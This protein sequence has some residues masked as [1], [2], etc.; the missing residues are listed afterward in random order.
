M[1]NTFVELL[2]SFGLSSLPAL[3]LLCVSAVSKLI[4]I[5][6]SPEANTIFSKPILYMIGLATY[7]IYFHPLSSFPG[8][9][10]AKASSLWFVVHSFRGDLHEEILALHEEHGEIVRV[11]PN[12]LAV[13]NPESWKEIYGHRSGPE[14]GKDPAENFETD[15][16]H[17]NI[18]VADR[19][20]HGYLRK[21]LSNAVC[22]V[23]SSTPL[24]ITTYLA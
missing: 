18:L 16:A 17:A 19:Q 11:G 20:R 6:V 3:F 8:P 24:S 9:I 2:K 15:P 12:E 22:V 7:N 10:F 14:N 5:V 23:L 4:S 1:S 13:I 21:L